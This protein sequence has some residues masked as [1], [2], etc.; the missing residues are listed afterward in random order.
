MQGRLD[1][2][3]PL[4]RA[5]LARETA[6]DARLH[7]FYGGHLTRL[8]RLDEAERELRSA[9]PGPEEISPGAWDTHP[10]DVMVAFIALHEAR[11]QPRRAEEYQRLREA[12]RQ[13]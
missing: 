6:P 13:R 3:D 11:G 8:G 12:A 9:T 2:A 7:L 10:D 5:L 4:F 1:E